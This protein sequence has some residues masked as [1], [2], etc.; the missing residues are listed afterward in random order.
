[1]TNSFKKIVQDLRHSAM[2]GV[3]Y[4]LTF[5]PSGTLNYADKKA[6]EAYLKYQFE[7][8]RDT[9]IIPR[10]DELDEKLA[11]RAPQSAPQS[12]PRAGTEC[13]GGNLGNPIA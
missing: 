4:S 7:L 5:A 3:P 13:T 12:T 2:R 10:L 9:W 8:W 6:L 11:R 1:M